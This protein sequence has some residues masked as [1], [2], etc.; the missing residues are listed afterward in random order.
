V[1]YALVASEHLRPS[2]LEDQPPD[3]RVAPPQLGKSKRPLLLLLIEGESVVDNYS[4]F[5]AVD[6]HL[7][8]VAARLIGLLRQ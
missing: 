1:L 7:H 4:L 8:G 3:L 6:E 5:L 2:L